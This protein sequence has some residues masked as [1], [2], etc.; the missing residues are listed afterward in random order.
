MPQKTSA[1]KK[2]RTAQRTS[3]RGG[4]GTSQRRSTKGRAT[5]SRSRNG[6]GSVETVKDTVSSGTR[7]VGRAV[8]ATA[9]KAKTPLIAGG[10]AVAGLAGGFALAAN[11][12]RT[13]PRTVL[14]VPM[15]KSRSVLETTR[16]LASGAENVGE[17][18][19]NVGQLATEVRRMREEAGSAK[20]RSPIEVVLDG[21]TARREQA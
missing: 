11:S 14:G 20:R 21:L 19:R 6:G 12:R 16:N 9:K 7:E 4:S 18:G 3:G 5:Q 10:A 15:P 2:R 13:G 8:E 1:T 17:L